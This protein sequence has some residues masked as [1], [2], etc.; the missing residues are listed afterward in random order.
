MSWWNTKLSR[1]NLWQLWGG[2]TAFRLNVKLQQ[3]N[4]QNQGE[5][6]LF[7]NGRHPVKNWGE[8]HENEVKRAKCVF[9]LLTK[10]R[11]TAVPCTEVHKKKRL[12]ERR[13][14]RYFSTNY[15]HGFKLFE[16]ML[17]ASHTR[18]CMIHFKESETR[19]WKGKKRKQPIT[20]SAGKRRW[21]SC[22]WSSFAFD[23]LRDWRELFWPIK[24][25]SKSRGILDY[26]G[27]SS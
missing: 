17:V 24:R 18:V 27:L 4:N 20:W 10:C 12:I 21:P 7:Q 22:R 8:L 19:N 16:A 1:L 14:W 23:R 2:F 11:R 26:L 15:M 9:V 3:P 5:Y 25:E 6:D 13:T